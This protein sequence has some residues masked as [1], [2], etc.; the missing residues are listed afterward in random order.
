[1]QSLHS[2]ES[3]TSAPIHP[4][5]ADG[6]NEEDKMQ[7]LIGKAAVGILAVSLLATGCARAGGT[8]PANSADS[9]FPNGEVVKVIVPYD[10]GGVTDVIVRL[11]AK[12]M[13]EELGT[14][15]QVVNKPGAAGSV[16]LTELSGEKP[17]GLTI[18]S[19]NMPS[20]FGYLDPSRNLPYTIK[21]FTPISGLALSPTVF[22]VRADSPWKSF[23]DLVDAAASTPGKITLAGT[24]TKTSDDAL[25]VAALESAGVDFNVVTIDTGGA[26]KVTQLLGGQMQVVVGSLGTVQS[27]LAS[28]QARILGVATGERS[29]FIPDVPT[30]TELGYEVDTSGN[31]TLAAPAGTDPKA[32][33]VLEKA[34][35]AAL[36]KP[37]FIKAANTAGYEVAY[38]NSK[39]LGEYWSEQET[40]TKKILGLN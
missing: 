22:A 13:S 10:A 27:A 37:D 12:G 28:G 1:M 26:D 23:K 32:V 11:V 36:K 38:R 24:S 7:K 19:F 20:G 9:K 14:T 25:A 8:S 31:V 40:A 34:V 33:E 4:A 21:S 18:G 6:L 5:S 3:A 39:E 30:L 2:G 35:D 15:V 29:E 17:D 16:G